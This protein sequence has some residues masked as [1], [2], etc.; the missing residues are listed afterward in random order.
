M[1]FVELYSH[2]WWGTGWTRN[3]GVAYE[4]G[5]GAGAWV[6]NRAQTYEAIGT[7][8]KDNIAQV[9]GNAWQVTRY[10]YFES[11]SSMRRRQSIHYAT[12][13]RLA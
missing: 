1:S 10:M 11:L 4:N 9:V 12:M 5:D 6:R 13:W 8:T 3:N 2:C 7:D